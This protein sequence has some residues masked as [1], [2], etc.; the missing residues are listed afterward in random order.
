M[1]QML[2]RLLL[3]LLL[4]YTSCNEEFCTRWVPLDKITSSASSLPDHRRLSS[5]TPPAPAALKVTMSVNH[6]DNSITGSA[7]TIITQHKSGTHAHAS[8]QEV[9]F[10]TLCIFIGVLTRTWFE[11]K[12][13]FKMVPYTVI[14]IGIGGIFGFISIMTQWDDST[15]AYNH[16]CHLLHNQTLKPNG[17]N[18]KV[19][20]CKCEN[21]F[22][23]LN[24]NILHNTSPYVILYVFL[25]PL[26]FE[27]A[28]FMD[29]HIF[30]RSFAG[31]AALA[32]LGVTVATF[33]TGYFLQ[34][35]ASTFQGSCINYEP[36]ANFDT[37]MMMGAMLS[38]TDP[39][40][41]V[42]LLKTLGASPSLGTL[43]EGESLL[44]DGTAYV[45]ECCRE[46][47]VGAAAARSGSSVCFFNVYLFL[48]RVCFSSISSIYVFY[49]YVLCLSLL[50][51]SFAFMS[52][53][54]VEQLF[55]Y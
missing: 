42:Q 33:V 8:A 41:V 7:T 12:L 3:A 36:L 53:L 23:L 6:T 24:V 28:F 46:G 1:S 54:K 19:G 31:I 30:V 4:R 9:G 34:Y 48:L 43:I 18:L 13:F 47:K 45:S 38:A 35:V 11:P 15:N 10:L 44:N 21:W 49:V 40:A 37:A 2:T 20:D 14:L 25:P 29:I 26:I 50:S 51:S 16:H 55:T 32:V 52:I 5:T 22:D 17:C 27:S 39:V